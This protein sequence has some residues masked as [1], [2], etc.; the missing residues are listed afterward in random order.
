M[1][2]SDTRQRARTILRSVFG[3]KATFRE[4]QLE[5]ITALVDHRQRVVVVQRTGWGK[6]LVY[7]IAS[8][9]LRERGAGRTLLISPL[10]ALI[11]TRSRCPSTGDHVPDD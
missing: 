11:A 1:S 8:A 5:P 4:G 3:A 2:G 9:I 7:F 10:L 6:S